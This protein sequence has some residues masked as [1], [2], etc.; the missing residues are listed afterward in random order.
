MR[1][2]ERIHALKNDI[3]EMKDEILSRSRNTVK[4]R[5]YVYVSEDLVVSVADVGDH[6]RK[7]YLI[8][9]EAETQTD[10][11]FHK[12]LEEAIQQESQ[13]IEVDERP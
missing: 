3:P 11:S 2:S 12:Q 10:A 7:P 6:F 4:G 8:A 1:Q 13:Y 5:N 9:F